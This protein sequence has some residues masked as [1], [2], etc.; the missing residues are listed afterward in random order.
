MELASFVVMREV[1]KFSCVPVTHTKPLQYVL[2]CLIFSLLNHPRVPSEKVPIP[3]GKLPIFSKE[4]SVLFVYCG[5]YSDS[6]GG[7]HPDGKEYLQRRVQVSVLH[8]MVW[9]LIYGDGISHLCT[10]LFHPQ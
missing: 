4:G 10:I 2:K 5:C 8:C 9:N 1:S 7:Q 3:T 6:M